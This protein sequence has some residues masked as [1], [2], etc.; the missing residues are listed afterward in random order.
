MAASTLGYF[1]GGII[2]ALLLG[3]YSILQ[4]VSTKQGIGPG[5]LMMV[6]GFNI[7]IVGLVYCLVSK[8]YSISIRSGLTA[9]LTGIVWGIAT[10]LIAIALSKYNVAI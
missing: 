6:M 2:P 1:I 9:S 7:M 3:I 8:E 5:M 4:K 10:V